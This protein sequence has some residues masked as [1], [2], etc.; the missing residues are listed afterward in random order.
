VKAARLDQILRRI[1]DFFLSS[2]SYLTY[3]S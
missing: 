3:G 2:H 1:W